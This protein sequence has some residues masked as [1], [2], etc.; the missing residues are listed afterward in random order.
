MTVKL[1]SFGYPTFTDK[2]LPIVKEFLSA[3]GE[4]LGKKIVVKGAYGA[5]DSRH[6]SKLNIPILMMKPMGDG[7]HSESEW[8][9]I[10]SS[11]KFYIGLEL[12]LNKLEKAVL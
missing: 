1:G 4:A 3:M 12:F 2:N 10:S 9:S 11:Y 5:S 6:F 7:I 8:L